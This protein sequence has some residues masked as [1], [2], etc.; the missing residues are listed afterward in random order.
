V[1]YEIVTPPTPAVS[2]DDAKAYYRV[3]GN[4]EDAVITQTIASATMQAS[5]I[6]GLGLGVVTIDV[7][8]EDFSSAKL[9][10][11]PAQSVESVTYTAQDGTAKVYVDY[12]LKESVIDFGTPP[13]DWDGGEI[14]VRVTTG[15]AEIPD[16]IKM[17]ILITGLTL[18]EHR[19]SL[20]DGTIVSDK[21][22]RYHDHLL[23]EYRVGLV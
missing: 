9:P 5:D 14:V 18:F 17:W 3:I 16:R 10:K 6:T 21:K 23:D 1:R 8:L 11:P 13:D 12:A 15:Y 22:K 2:L 4:D 7:Y 19:E 20:V